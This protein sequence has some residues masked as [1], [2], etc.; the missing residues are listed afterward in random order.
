VVS[1]W[2]DEVY[3]GLE[4]S[5][6]L[7]ARRGLPPSPLAGLGGRIGLRERAATRLDGLVRRLTSAG[8]AENAMSRSMRV[9]ARGAGVG[10]AT[11]ARAEIQ[12]V[13]VDPAA[14]PAATVW[15]TLMR[16]SG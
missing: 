3:S 10:A 16:Q 2:P 12:M 6:W 7:S 11:A 8:I 5:G 4:R 15:P 14:P 9:A 1:L 13:S